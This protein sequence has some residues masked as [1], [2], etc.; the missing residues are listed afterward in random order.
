MRA[1]TS[2][3][4]RLRISWAREWKSDSDRGH[5]GFSIFS[6]MMVELRCNM[7]AD[8][9]IETPENDDVR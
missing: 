8:E 4:W 6:S 1:P 7:S 9:G 2:E 3:S 5:I